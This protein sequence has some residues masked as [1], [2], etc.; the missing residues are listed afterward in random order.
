[1]ETLLTTKLFI[2]KTRS[3]FVY[4]SR[5]IDHLNQGLNKKL[6]LISAPAGYGKTTLV[7][8]WLDQLH[9]K[10]Q[11]QVCWLSLDEEDSDTALFFRYLAVSIENLPDVQPSLT[12]L[13]NTKQNFSEKIL[14]KAF[15]QGISQVSSPFIFVMDDYHMLDSQPIDEALSILIE[16]M[17]AQMT[18]VLI[19][20]IDPGF[21]ISRL[22]AQDE[23]VEI[24]I[25]DL[26]FNQEETACFLEESMK[27]VLPAK[28]INAL[29]NRTEGWIT[30]LKMAA[31]SVQNRKDVDIERFVENFTG[32]HRYITDY[33]TDEVL[34]Q[35]SPEIQSFLLNTSPLNQLCAELCDAVY[36]LKN[37]LSSQNILEQLESSNTF[38]IA[39]DEKRRWFR[40]HHLF[41]DLLRQKISTE[42][43]KNI[44]KKASQWSANNNRLADAIEYALEAQA[45]D[46]AIPLLIE[47]GLSYVFQGK[48]T[49]LRRWID[50]LPH[51][52]MMREP[53]ICLDYAWVLVNLG[54]KN[55]VEPY[56][57]AAE[58]VTHCDPGVRTV[59][60]IIRAN[61]ARAW[62]D[63]AVIKEEASIS[64]QLAAP[65][66]AVARC[67]AHLQLG[68]AHMLS[69][70]ANPKEAIRSLKDA[71]ILARLSG[72]M[73]TAFLSGGYLGLAYLLQ[74]D[75]E[76]A[77]MILQ[78]SIS[79]AEKYGLEQSPLL[80]YVHLG[81]A[82]LAYFKN[83]WNEVR[84]QLNQVQHYAYFSDE[85]SAIYRGNL[86]LTLVECLAGNDSAT[87][88]A[89][90][91]AQE[92]AATLK[93][94]DIPNQRNFVED[95]LKQPSPTTEKIRI[96]QLLASGTSLQFAQSIIHP[97][98]SKPKQGLIDPLSDRELEILACITDG[99]KNQEIAEKMIISL[100]TVLYHT[101][102]IY[103]KLGVNK[104]AHAILKAQ[105]LKL[106]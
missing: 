29:E 101:K 86:L 15:L 80:V 43:A 68:A 88:Q 11:H 9:P 46:L 64:L 2:P 38:L 50:T 94:P 60:A 53:R 52:L 54:E 85:Q 22:R 51:H 97:Q 19:S 47:H 42:D 56:L 74:N 105:E 106:L 69:N 98:G 84:H 79:F 8:T 33:L 91:K 23:L 16:R 70:Q 28:Q 58:T 93:N 31:L 63:L 55:G 102:N 72:N 59:T 83:N 25:D 17:P 104:R 41:A 95:F 67:T 32:S 40:Y 6:I 77:S 61:N 65:D 96:L 44:Q 3:D 73:N 27:L 90:L 12:R 99:L 45:W 7:T 39:L 5:L 75:P 62:E 13:I 87:K 30:G 4:R 10:D 57:Q 14:I 37:Q 89:W 82:H 66:N 92:S 24:R 35:V 18:L 81:F 71:L 20:R 100:N 103:S 1:M 36:P 78:E 76:S 48:L 26:R 34:N 49:T 21:P